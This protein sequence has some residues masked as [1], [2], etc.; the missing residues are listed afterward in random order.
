MAL[1]PFLRRATSALSL[2]AI[3]VAVSEFWFY[4]V[5]EEVGHLGILLAYGGLAWIFLAVWSRLRVRAESIIVAA[6]L[7][8]FLIEGVP[9]PVL[10]SAPPFTILWTSLAWH[11]LISVLLGWLAVRRALA[12]SR[13]MAASVCAAFGLGLGIWNAYTWSAIE[14]PLGIVFAWRPTSDFAAQVVVGYALFLG[15]HLGADRLLRTPPDIPTAEAWTLAA[16]GTLVA[17][18]TAVGSGLWA[19]A[20]ILPIAVL[21]CLWVLRR[22]LALRP[23]AAPDPIASAPIPLGRWTITLLTPAGAIAAYATMSHLRLELE[24]NVALILT[25]GPLSLWL[26]GRAIWACLRR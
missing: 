14:A 18:A 26:L 2:G 25:A 19:T 22:D 3:V 10:Y 7:L 1:L 5:E 24:A 4:P 16:L 9:V 21:A 6:A 8:G 20:W 11:M 17:L 13:V 12:G 15:G 23:R